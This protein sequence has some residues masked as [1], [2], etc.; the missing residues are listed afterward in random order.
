MAS[1][2]KLDPK[3][4]RLDDSPS[5]G[6]PPS[7][8]PSPPGSLDLSISSRS[9]QGSEGDG[10]HQ[11]STA[12]GCPAGNAV[13][14]HGELLRGTTLRPS[15]RQ[16]AR[17]V[18]A[19]KCAAVD[20]EH[21][22][23][24]TSLSA[25]TAKSEAQLQE[26]QGLPGNDF[27][28][29][30]AWDD[31]NGDAVCCFNDHGRLTDAEKPVVQQTAPAESH[32]RQRRK[33]N[34]RNLKA[35]GQSMT[36]RRMNAFGTCSRSPSCNDKE[37]DSD[38]RKTECE[39]AVLSSKHD[40]Q[41]RPH[42]ARP[43]SETLKRLY[44]DYSNRQRRRQE[45]KARHEMEKDNAQKGVRHC[46]PISHR[47]AS[48]SREERDKEYLERRR[49]RVELGEALRLR[50]EDEEM[51]E[52]TFYPKINGCAGRETYRRRQAE[53]KCVR[54]AKQQ[55][56]L[57][58]QLTAVARG[59]NKD[60]RRF[61]KSYERLFRQI[62]AEETQGIVVWL[63]KGEGSEYLKKQIAALMGSGDAGDVTCDG[64][65]EAAQR[66][67]VEELVAA[68]QEEVQRRTTAEITKRQRLQ[69]NE[70]YIRKLTLVHELEKLEAEAAGLVSRYPDICK[71]SGFVSDLTQRL[72][73]YTGLNLNVPPPTPA[74]SPA[75][76]PNRVHKTKHM[77]DSMTMTTQSDDVPPPATSTDMVRNTTVGNNASCSSL[78][79]VR[80][81]NEVNVA[82]GRSASDYGWTGPG[83]RLQP[84]PCTMRSPPVVMSPQYVAFPRPPP[85]LVQQQHWYT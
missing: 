28:V 80:G 68:S 65:P 3:E 56:Q 45:L 85:F 22:L 36:V 23:V 58:Q 1:N 44:D 24:F 27:P 60:G 13:K 82:I 4:L 5:C 73:T 38:A 61:R 33:A 42:A 41:G 35:R 37:R 31:S 70:H 14:W 16:D 76:D 50:R 55:Q 64:L 62:Q 51:Q 29:F 10:E 49:Q 40:R 78:G 57:V 66:Q 67:I 74:A 17:P 7:P 84:Q 8:R 25:I 54:L 43:S 83:P 69:T 48:R 53:V 21:N 79:D 59:E 18:V 71:N 77:V 81:G 63:Q 15:A 47:S 6:P 72:S 34:T 26:G 9:S 32:Q 19:E 75:V 12:G 11:P 39:T 2:P 20:Q 46:A 52:C 30:A